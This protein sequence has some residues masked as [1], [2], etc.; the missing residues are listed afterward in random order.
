MQTAVPSGRN[1]EMPTEMLDEHIGAGESDIQT[2]IGD[3]GLRLQQQHAALCS[4]RESG[5]RKEVP[6][7]VRN[8][9]DRWLADTPAKC[10]SIFKRKRLREIVEKIAQYGLYMIAE[11]SETAG[12]CGAAGQ[13][14]RQPLQRGVYLFL[15]DGLILNVVEK[16][17]RKQGAKRLC[18]RIITVCGQRDRLPSGGFQLCSRNA[19]FQCNAAAERF[20]SEQYAGIADDHATSGERMK[21]F[22]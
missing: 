17:L 2:D 3:R 7:T 6:S 19:D 15:V 5:T 14:I 11:R 1:A 21:L 9:C 12:A 8:R 10:G 16:Q 20:Q 18:R 13:V 22:G 4:R